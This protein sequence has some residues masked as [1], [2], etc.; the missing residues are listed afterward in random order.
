M[1]YFTAEYEDAKELL[2]LGAAFDFSR[3]QW[4]VENYAD[5]AKFSKFLG[6]NIITRAPIR[7]LRAGFKCPYCGR[8]S[9]A[10]AVC[11]GAY[12]QDFGST[13][14]GAGEVNILYGFEKVKGE[15]REILKGEF[16]LKKRYSEP[17]GYDYL[18]NGC[19]GCGKPF[20]NEYLFGETDSPFF[21]DTPEKCE[22]LK[23]YVWNHEG[24]VCLGGMIK[25][26]FPEAVLA[27]C[28]EIQIKR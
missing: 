16:G 17:D 21:I 19:N 28:G 10:Y 1:I 18:L 22:K 15:L 5:Y 14:Y 4:R 27:K 26:S 24:D 11:T 23:V 13:L 12:T 2:S 9:Q 8:R 25:W 3:W 6:G 20:P 7:I